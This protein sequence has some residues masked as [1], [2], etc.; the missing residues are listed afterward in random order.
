MV[1]ISQECKVKIEKL[2]K[3]ING[4]KQENYNLVCAKGATLLAF[5]TTN[6]NDTL[7]NMNIKEDELCKIKEDLRNREEE[8]YILKNMIEKRDAMITNLKDHRAKL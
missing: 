5:S 3:E 6:P 1:N 7:A 4:L 8:V 2:E